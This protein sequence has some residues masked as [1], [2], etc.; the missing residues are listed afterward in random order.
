MQPTIDLLRSLDAKHPEV[1]LAEGLSPP[2]YHGKLVLRSA[3]ES[4]RGSYIASSTTGRHSMVGRTLEQ[5]KEAGMI[6]DF[7][8]EGRTRRH[9]FTV[10][11]EPNRARMAAVEVKGGEGNSINISQRPMWAT[12]F[13]VWCHLDGAIVNQPAHGAASIVFGRLASEMVSGRKQVDALIIKDSF[14]GT[15]ARPCPKFGGRDD[16]GFETPPCIFLFPRRIPAQDDPEPPVHDNT[17]LKFPF[18][19]L[20]LFGVP[21]AEHDRHIYKVAIRVFADQNGRPRRE[22]SVTRLGQL[23]GRRVASA[24]L[25]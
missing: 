9:D 17:T 11:M 8:Y 15:P 24:V 5:M 7:Q 21:P 25:R 16:L 2:D 3:V 13:V 14:C 12:E 23:L 6:E 10:I 20:H 4:I 19:M 22:T 18:H 1:L